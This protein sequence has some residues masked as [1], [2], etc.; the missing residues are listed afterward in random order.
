[1][2]DDCYFS[3]PGIGALYVP[4]LDDYSERFLP[5]ADFLAS[6]DKAIDV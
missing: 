5:G 6:R 2:I 1:M 4:F 3:N